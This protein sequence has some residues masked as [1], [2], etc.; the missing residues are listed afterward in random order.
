ML[1]Y[2]KWLVAGVALL[3]LWLSLLQY[4]SNHALDPH[5]VTV[6]KALPLLAVV[7]F[8]VYS[9][10]V[11]TLSVMAVQDFPEASKELDEHVVAAKLDL[12]KKGFKF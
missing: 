3:T 9:L 2:Q 1:K 6:V 12:A 4:V 10:A 8:G 11:I 7:S 5:V